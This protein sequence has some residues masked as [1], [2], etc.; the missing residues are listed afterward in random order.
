MKG[1][2]SGDKSAKVRNNNASHLLKEV[3]RDLLVGALCAALEDGAAVMLAQ[4]RDAGAICVTVLHGNERSKAY[5]S[6]ADEML[7]LIS[8]LAESFG[9]NIITT[10]GGARRT[11]RQSETSN[12]KSPSED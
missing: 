1:V 5:A 11:V 10:R 2:F 7:Q 3:D 12:G 6:D 9:I 4:T 8:D